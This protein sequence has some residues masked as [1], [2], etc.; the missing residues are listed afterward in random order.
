MGNLNGIAKCRVEALS[1]SLFRLS[2]PCFHQVPR[3]QWF[4][5]SLP[6]VISVCRVFAL[7]CANDVNHLVFL[8]AP[9]QT[10][11]TSTSTE[12][13]MQKADSSGMHVIN[14]VSPLYSPT[15]DAY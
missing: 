12:K 14:A 8:A 5:F 6:F 4:F 2:Y 1:W 15:R 13:A 7:P 10:S 3:L 9:H 11:K